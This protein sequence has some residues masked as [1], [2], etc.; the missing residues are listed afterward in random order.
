MRAARLT[1]LL[2]LVFASLAAA[3]PPDPAPSG[4]QP[5]DPADSPLVPAFG[6]R[7]GW[8]R[9]LTP[10]A[11]HLPSVLYVHRN[12]VLVVRFPAAWTLVDVQ[13]GDPLAWTT[14]WRSN[15][16]L[17]QPAVAD[18]R[19]NLTLFMS[20]G[21]IL[22]AALVEVSEH[23]SGRHGQ[24]YVGPEDWLV[25]QLL[26]T[27]PARLR[28]DAADLDVG[29]LLAEPETLV[30][31][32][33]GT[34]GSTDPSGFDSSLDFPAGLW[35]GA[36]ATAGE[37]IL[38]DDSADEASAASPGAPESPPALPDTPPQSV[39]PDPLVGPS[40]P[41]GV[42][43]GVVALADPVSARPAGSNDAPDVNPVL[44][45][46]VAAAV[47]DADA[48]S[49][50]DPVDLESDDTDSAVPV[51]VA[52]PWLRSGVPAGAMVTGGERLDP[53]LRARLVHRALS[54]SLPDLVLPGVAPVAVDSPPSQTVGA[55]PL[56]AP[57]LPPP[58]GPAG[59]FGSEPLVSARELD[60]AGEAVESARSALDDARRAA[61]ERVA[62]AL[63]QA[64]QEVEEWR[65]TLTEQIQMSLVWDPPVPPWT[66]PLWHWGAFHDGRYTYIR[67]LAPDPQFYDVENDVVLSATVSDLS[68][69]RLDGVYSELAVSVRDPQRR[70]SLVQVI[71]RR[72][73]ELEHP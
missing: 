32:L 51:P 58:S 36:A 44:Q 41:A 33:E 31:R 8:T 37:P 47:S 25:S 9:Y 52:G 63:L 50:A 6:Q 71:L 1:V 54:G 26:A 45:P 27:L 5:V 17:V 55:P 62:A 40:L 69:Y 2:S 7:P 43:P 38:G 13:I 65:T 24:V 61:G 64:D 22:Q 20:D 53:A 28:D 10:V 66:P 35:S 30:E 4:V 46:D 59:A 56:G 16:V 72:R 39:L 23:T 18:S 21:R 19:T 14:S 57:P 48:D 49:L 12:H 29:P 70:G 68:L 15:V 11:G 42:L 67:M 60:A 34:Y 73:A 3:Q